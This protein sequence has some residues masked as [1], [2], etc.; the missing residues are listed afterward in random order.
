MVLFNYIFMAEKHFRAYHR[1]DLDPVS[2]TCFKNIHTSRTSK[3]NINSLFF[4][5]QGCREILKFLGNERINSRVTYIIRCKSRLTLVHII[6]NH[7]RPSV[8]VTL[9]ILDLIPLQACL[10]FT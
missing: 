3:G 6:T 9:S 2:R 4:N 8:K 1:G 5:V 7:P 10:R